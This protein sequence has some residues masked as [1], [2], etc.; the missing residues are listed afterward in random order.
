MRSA[1]EFACVHITRPNTA[2]LQCLAVL[3]FFQHVALTLL[4]IVAEGA[5]GVQHPPP[6]Q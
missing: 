2:S 3:D 1:H 6:Q 4:L 5:A